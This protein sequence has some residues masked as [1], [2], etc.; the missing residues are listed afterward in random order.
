ME[1]DTTKPHRLSKELKELQRTGVVNQD[2]REH[3]AAHG[4]GSSDAYDIL[5]QLM[6][7][8]H[9]ALAYTHE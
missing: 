4:F 9:D 2:R 8:A 3:E 5:S 6:T 1:Q 7:C